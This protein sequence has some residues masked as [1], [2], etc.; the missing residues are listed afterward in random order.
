MV[1][2][3]N[4]TSATQ[5]NDKV[6]ETQ[7]LPS[8]PA[9]DLNACCCILKSTNNTDPGKSAAKL[10]K[11]HRQCCMPWYQQ[12]ETSLLALFLEVLSK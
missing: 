7:M 10:V 8:K 1:A 6:E 3:G 9:L 12:S 2:S 11:Y 5:Y 4:A